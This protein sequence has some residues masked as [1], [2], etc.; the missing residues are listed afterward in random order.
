MSPKTQK[1]LIA[2]LLAPCLLAL[3]ACMPDIGILSD[4]YKKP[5]VPVSAI[6]TPPEPQKTGPTLY[7][8]AGHGEALFG[9]GWQEFRDT[10]FALPQGQYVNVKIPRLRNNEVM[11]V[12]ALFDNSGQKMIFCPLVDAAPGQRIACSSLYAMED[13]LQDGIK[14]TLDIPNALRGGAITCAYRQANLKP[15]TLPS[16]GGN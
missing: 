2:A 10:T 11:T 6:T 12:Q 7:C 5:E 16:S 9:T 1:I 15:L 4:D 14:R 13:D 3:A 8:K